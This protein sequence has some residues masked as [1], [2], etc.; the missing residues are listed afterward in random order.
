[1]CL[2]PSDGGGF[3][4]EAASLELRVLRFGFDGWKSCLVPFELHDLLFFWFP[5]LCA[6]KCVDLGSA[7]SPTWHPAYA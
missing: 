2:G 1:M 6:D 4:L 5:V 3:E 7:T